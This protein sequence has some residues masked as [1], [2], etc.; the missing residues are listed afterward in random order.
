MTFIIANRT[1]CINVVILHKE[2]NVIYGY[3]N[4]E[5][6]FRQNDYIEKVL[7]EHDTYENIVFCE[8][9]DYKVNEFKASDKSVDNEE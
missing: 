1:R 7:N 2:G 4:D 6:K 5:E 9:K 3:V 8:G